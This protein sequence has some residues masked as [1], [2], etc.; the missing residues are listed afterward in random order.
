MIF[1]SKKQPQPGLLF[2]SLIVL[3][4]LALSGCGQSSSSAN[5]GTDT[6]PQDGSTQTGNQQ[7]DVSISGSLVYTAGQTVTLDGRAS[8]ASDGGT[9]SYQWTKTEGPD[10]ALSEASTATISFVA[11]AVSSTTR[12]T[13]KLTVTDGQN[14]GITSVSIHISPATPNPASNQAPSAKIIA[15]Q[16]VTSGE[17][18][19]LDGS[20]SS[21]PDGDTLS[22]QWA[23]TAGP[24]IALSNTTDSSLSFIA[25]SVDQT[26]QISFLLTVSDGGGLSN[27]TSV[28]IQVSPSEPPPPSNQ[29][30]SAKI[31]APQSATSG[32]TV[33]LDGSSSSDPD[34]D[35]VTYL[36]TQTQGESITL[37]NNTGST[38]S[39]VA[40]SV[41]Q[42]TSYTFQLSVSDGS[43]SDKSSVQF[44][45]LPVATDPA[46][47]GL[48]VSGTQILDSNDNAFVMRGI[49]VAHAWYPDNTSSS[50]S[51]IANTGANTVRIVLSSG[52]RWNKTSESMVSS[53]IE[54]AKANKLIAILEVHDTTGYG[55]E[56]AAITLSQAAD[57]W[58]SIKGAL[59]GQEDYAV[60]DIGNEPLGNGQ[61][62]S[63]WTDGHINAIK[64]LRDA[65]LKN[66]IMV[67]AANWGQDWKNIMRDNAVSVLAA[68]P[69]KNVIFSVHMY[70]IYQD[71]NTINNYMMSF[72]Q[73]DLAL[74]VGEFGADH[75]GEDVDEASI[76]SYATQYGYG[77]LGW[78]W[79]GNSGGTESLDIV[80]NFDA[81][82]LTSWGEI[83]IN[84]NNGIKATSQIARVFSG[85]TDPTVNNQAPSA[86]ITAP[87]S[88]TSGETVTLDGSGSSDPDGDA[89]SYIWMKTAGPNITLSNTT[90]SSFSFVA[91]SVDQTEQ[92]SFQLTVSDGEL[93]S[94][95]SVSM[96]ISPIVDNSAPS[97][98][99]RSPLAD[100]SGISPTAQ[101]SVTFNEALLESSVTSQSVV[102]TQNGNPVPGSVSYDSNSNSVTF[103][104]TSA[105]SGG[106]SYTVT[107]TQSL[108]DVTGNAFAGASW[109]FTTGVCGTAD[110]NAS[111]TL[112]CPS[113]QVINEVTFASYGNPGGSCGSFT[114][115]TCNAGNSKKVVSD[116]CIGMDVCTLQASNENFGDPCSDTTKKLAAQVA[117]GMAPDPTPTPTPNPDGGSSGCGSNPGLT[118]GRRNMTVDGAHREYIIDLPDNYDKNKPYRLIFAWHWLGGN[119]GAV[120]GGGYYGLRNLARSEAIFVAPDK[121]NV[122]G[123]DDNGWP[124]TNGRDMRFL[125]AMLDEIKGSLCVDNDRVFSTGWSYGGMMSFA[126]GREF[127]GTIRAIAPMSGS[128]W[129]PFD[130][131]DKG[132]PTAAWISHGIYDSV[133]GHDGPGVEAR[134]YYVK[135]NHCSNNTVPTD[136]SP[137]VEYQGCD[138]DSPVVWCSFVGP[139]GTPD[140]GPTAI[141][142]FFKRF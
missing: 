33:T 52:D 30:P 37:A 28:S 107:L 103:Q 93:S 10:T 133:V 105:L 142:N 80:N 82:S 4:I 43:L 134:D 119:A 19:T 13:Y 50:L 60:I 70:Q 98:V 131:K 108:T 24:D 101:I 116:A 46:T 68:D 7:L 121:Y 35:T 40:P 87:Q 83:L 15:H 113:G 9:L 90:G 132:K 21:D 115:G 1:R 16:S 49:N 109:S 95:S 84:G 54:Q 56:S 81:T 130:D 110:E 6:Q 124:N 94:S 63:A 11:P 26:E 32:E 8:F 22:Y 64:S 138:A 65:G 74:V 88:A 118:S 57:Y 127:A 27:S 61:P 114:T 3:L 31:T 97:I 5:S 89:L 59:I 96:Q 100:Q 53:L 126:V 123:Q 34:G 135:A 47:T 2:S 79:S 51:D 86:K 112:T 78:S 104:S 136:P 92:V 25:P 20:G 44:I 99:S 117:C 41:Q 139:H 17:T 120:A 122:N 137:C 129:T 45:V 38:L 77:Y 55:E 76:M 48:H 72:I 102:V 111:L 42:S 58:K 18:V 62:A 36:W 14:T 23:K 73:N 75:Q 71:A 141:W 85:S 106:V 66:A 39:F 140:F 125:S 91:P 12:L 128:L 29:A 67:D 69:Q